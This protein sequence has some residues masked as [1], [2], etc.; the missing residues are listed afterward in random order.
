MTSESSGR[1][2]PAP[3]SRPILFG[4]ERVWAILLYYGNEWDRAD[5]LRVDV[6]ALFIDKRKL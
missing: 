6:I 4:I 5:W 2:R 3:R 1:L